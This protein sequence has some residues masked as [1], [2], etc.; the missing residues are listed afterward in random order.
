MSSGPLA[1]PYAITSTP[2]GGVVSGIA[3]RLLVH[4]VHD[5]LQ[6][7]DRRRRQHAVAKVEDVTV[8]STGGGQ[9]RARLAFDR[10]ARGEQHTRV[11]VALHGPGAGAAGAG[12][13]VL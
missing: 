3:L 4:E 11:E 7:L 10:L 12:P 5:E 8:A 6:V 13:P 1:V 2:M 9:H